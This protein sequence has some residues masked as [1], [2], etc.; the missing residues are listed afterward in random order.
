MRTGQILR[1]TRKKTPDKVALVFGDQRWNYAELDSVTDRVGAGLAAAGVKADDRV[2]FW[3]PNCPE[4]LF[5]YLG[6]FKLGAIAVPLNHRYKLP[7]ARFAIEHSGATTLLMHQDKLPEIEKLS[8]SELGIA[9]GYLIADETGARKAASSRCGAELRSFAEFFETPSEQL[10]APAFGP[11]QLATIMY[12]SGT[13]SRPKGVV[14]SQESLW[15]CVRIQ[16][17]TM[18]FSSDDVHLITTSASH[19]AASFGQLFPNIY[20]GG[21][22]VMTNAPTPIEVADA[23]ARHRV[24]RCQ[25]LPPE[26]LDLV[27]YLE[28]HSADVGSLRAITCGG[29][30]VPHDTLHRFRAAVGFDVSELC[31]MTETITYATNPP[32]GKKRLGSVGLPAVQTEIKIVDEQ[33]EE[34]PRGATGE[35]LIRSRSNM[36]AYW[37]DTLHTTATLCDG[38]VASGDLGRIDDE[39]YLW[40]VGR[41]K[42]IIIRGGSN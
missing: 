40:F 15:H 2:A 31:G 27:E 7:E 26:L 34:L 29:D 20:A 5:A 41:Q 39:G 21:V 28:E 18:Q 16:T 38:W 14:Q 9:R 37:N 8:L 4:L 11:R 42:E 36:V 33:G 10:P 13:T 35:V 19:C 30:V 17:A 1:E 25:M 12:T 24:T 23:I 32:F 3:M 6:C 22:A